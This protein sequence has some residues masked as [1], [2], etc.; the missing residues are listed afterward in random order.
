M[1]CSGA[2]YFRV[3][4]REC[5]V[6]KW[7]TRCAQSQQDSRLLQEQFCCTLICLSKIVR[8]HVCSLRLFTEEHYYVLDSKANKFIG[9][10]FASNQQENVCPLNCVHCI[11]HVNPLCVQ[12]YYRASVNR[13][14]YGVFEFV[15][16]QTDWNLLL[17]KAIHVCFRS[18]LSL[19]SDTAY[20]IFEFFFALHSQESIQW[21]SADRTVYFAMT[22]VCNVFS[23]ISDKW[24]Y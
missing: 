8:F 11:F 22:T 1:I 13:T 23:H 14:S 24:A 16:C 17:N 20:F 12:A 2:A 21:Q 9:T 18:F 10:S 4:E 15:N 7:P 5:Q 6:N 19:I 3:N